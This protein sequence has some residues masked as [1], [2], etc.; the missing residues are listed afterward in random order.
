MKLHEIFIDPAEAFSRIDEHPSWLGPF[1]VGSLV[2]IVTIL[3]LAPIGQQLALRHLP[4]SAGEEVKAEMF[5]ILRLSTYYGVAAAPILTLLKWSVL[6]TLLFLFLILSGADISYRK[7]LALLGHASLVVSLDSLLSVLVMYLRGLDNI[8]SPA[9]VQSTVLS[10]S[11]FWG[12]A[13]HPAL[14]VVL[15]NLSVFMLWYLA[16][17]IFGVASV[18]RLDRWRA[19]LIVTLLW[20]LQTLFMA[21]IAMIFSR[22]TELSV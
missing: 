6:A 15:D 5:K 1:L 16:L 11:S 9:D 14:R 12:V 7:T 8:L 4:N 18:A 19:A 2:A 22:Y 21:G 3:L 13:L 20:G 17:L 10:L